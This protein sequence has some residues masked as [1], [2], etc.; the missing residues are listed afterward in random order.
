MRGK[1]IN[2]FGAK[3]STLPRKVLVLSDMYNSGYKRS[4][5]SIAHYS[6]ILVLLNRPN[7]L[8]LRDSH[9]TILDRR[10]ILGDSGARLRKLREGIISFFRTRRSQIAVAVIAGLIVG[11]ILESRVQ[12]TSLIHQ[13]Q[14]REAVRER[15]ANELLSNANLLSDKITIVDGE[16]RWLVSREKSFSESERPWLFPDP[17]RELGPRLKRD[18]KE[19]TFKYGAYQYLVNNPGKINSTLF[20]T[21][22]KLYD[23]LDH[24]KLTEDDYIRGITK[25][26]ETYKDIG[27]TAIYGVSGFR[28]MLGQ[29]EGIYIISFRELKRLSE[30][31]DFVNGRSFP[32]LPS[33]LFYFQFMEEEKRR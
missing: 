3:L 18:L 24:I 7:P 27:A 15:V 33:D 14:Y 11:V 4:C 17:Y 31:M 12:I 28:I 30:S 2:G 13:S 29:L 25:A 5:L 23:W 10:T 21:Y 16:L 22:K 19:K 9:V 8:I 26:Y 1:V 32:S 6:K 20:S